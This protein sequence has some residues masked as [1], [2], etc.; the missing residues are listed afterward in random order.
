M[1]RPHVAGAV[2]DAAL[3]KRVRIRIRWGR[4]IGAMIIE[5][6]LF[7][8]L[9]VVEDR[10]AAAATQHGAA[11]LHRGQ[12]IGMHMRQQA[13]GITHGQVGHIRR[14]RAG[15]GVGVKVNLAETAGADGAH[16]LSWHAHQEIEDR[17]VVHRQ[18]P[19]HIDIGAKTPQVRAHRLV[20]MQAPQAALVDQAAQVLH[21]G[22]IDI[23]MIHHQHQVPF[24]GF[25]REPGRLRTGGGDGLFDQH[26]LARKKSVQGQHE[27]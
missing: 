2:A 15:S 10:H 16:L 6:E 13:I 20:V 8:G 26:M 11:Y 14:A 25:S 17:Q 3:L 12:P 5:L 7:A 4:P 24:G 23:G 19:K 22:C 9:D 18:I 27:V 1:G 21:S